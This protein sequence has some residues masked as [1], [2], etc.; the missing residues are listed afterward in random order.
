MIRSLAIAAIMAGVVLTPAQAANTRT[1]ISGTGIDQAG[2]R[3][4]RYALQDTSVRAR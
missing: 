4:N 3:T 1:W 2:L